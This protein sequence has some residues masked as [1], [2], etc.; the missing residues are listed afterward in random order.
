[1]A[2]QLHKLDAVTARALTKP[3]RHS[4]GGGLYLRV[5][6][7]GWRGWCFLF[8]WQGRQ[9]EKSLGPFLPGH[10]EKGR[11]YDYVTLADARTKAA[12]MRVALAEGRDPAGAA[13]KSDAIPTF[14]EFADAHIEAMKPAWKNAKHIAQWQMTL[15][16]T[17]C[18]ALRRKPVNEINTADVLA[19]LQP[20]WKTK[21]ETAA[22]LRGRIEAVLD[23]AKAKGLRDG[24]NPAQ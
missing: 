24:E 12:A 23:A 19:V 1:M 15:G 2:R 20:I 21:T 11:R 14:G 13:R 3:G 8:R 6:P 22:R 17:Y 10:T 9:R 16:D 4:D 18:R 7:D 5:L